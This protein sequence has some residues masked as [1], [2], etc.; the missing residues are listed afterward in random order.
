MPRGRLLPPPTH[1]HTHHHPTP[2]PW[3]RSMPSRNLTRCIQDFHQTCDQ[4]AGCA[5]CALWRLVG[6]CGSVEGEVCV[7]REDYVMMLSHSSPPGR[8]DV[9]CLSQNHLGPTWCRARCSWLAY[10]CKVRSV[11]GAAGGRGGVPAAA[12]CRG[13][14]PAAPKPQALPACAQGG[15]AQSRAAALPAP[16]APAHRRPAAGCR[17]DTGASGA[18]RAQQQRQVQGSEAGW[19]RGARTAASWLRGAAVIYPRRPWP[20]T[21]TH[22]R[23]L[24][25][26]APTELTSEQT[27]ASLAA[28][29]VPAPWG[30]MEV[31]LF[32]WLLCCGAESLPN[33]SSSA[34]ATEWAHRVRRCAG[35]P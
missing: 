21:Q 29:F 25:C 18:Q 31:W 9:L 32:A 3:L 17:L 27:G 2:L 4:Q 6:A 20:A 24:R 30:E 35:D 11:I 26:S 34:A 12:G 23:P 7:R 13:G 19:W 33:V 8:D 10:A 22:R 28:V 5:G 1:P 16:N 15:D 14:V